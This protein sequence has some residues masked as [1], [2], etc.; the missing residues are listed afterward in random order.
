V[1]RT[2][3]RHVWDLHLKRRQP[4]SGHGAARLEAEDA[5]AVADDV[6][7]LDNVAAGAL[8]VE[9]RVLGGRAKRRASKVPLNGVV[10]AK[11]G[12]LNGAVD[13][14]PVGV[15]EGVCLSVAVPAPVAIEVC[16]VFGA[17]AECDIGC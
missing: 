4:R 1:T 2:R 9:P 5:D 11:H 3:N 8:L 15:E 10:K 12:A 13:E 14:V 7:L 17:A 6:V 16:G